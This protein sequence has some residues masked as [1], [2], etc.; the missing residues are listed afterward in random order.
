MLEITISYALLVY[1]FAKWLYSQ[2]TVTLTL[3]CSLSFYLVDTVT[4]YRKIV[5]GFAFK[6]D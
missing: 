4:V 1:L 5:K 3:Y 2:I 6:S